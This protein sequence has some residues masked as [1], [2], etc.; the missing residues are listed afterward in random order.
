VGRY[1]FAVSYVGT[2]VQVCP[3]PKGRGQADLRRVE[4]GTSPQHRVK[5]SIH[6][7]RARGVYSALTYRKTCV[8]PGRSVVSL[9]MS[10]ISE[11]TDGD[12]VNILICEKFHAASAVI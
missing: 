6:L 11:K 12:G 4:T 1:A 3:V 9:V 2:S 7:L 8:H 5:S 10:R